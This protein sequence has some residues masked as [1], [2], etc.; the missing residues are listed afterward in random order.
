MF[1][2]TPVHSTQ[3][4]TCKTCGKEFLVGYRTIE[5]DF[6]CPE[7]RVKKEYTDFEAGRISIW[8]RED[9]PVILQAEILQHFL[10]GNTV[11]CRWVALVPIES[12]SQIPKFTVNFEEIA[13]VPTSKGMALLLAERND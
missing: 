13:Q 8:P 4:Y 3:L 5:G 10:D 7:D 6:Y 2:W 1:Y 12:V 9:V 11:N